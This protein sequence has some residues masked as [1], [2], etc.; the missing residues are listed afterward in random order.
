M[1][2]E[3]MM[4]VIAENNIV[5]LLRENIVYE[6]AM[7]PMLS[8]ATIDDECAESLV[9]FVVSYFDYDTEKICNW[10][11][12]LENINEFDVVLYQYLYPS[13]TKILC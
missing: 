13:H 8:E 10:L 2:R 12:N 1:F 5:S 3:L 4:A 9:N 11:I 6:L 7:T